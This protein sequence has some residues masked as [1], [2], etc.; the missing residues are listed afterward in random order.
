MLNI[1]LTAYSERS[2]ICQHCPM[3][4]L[5]VNEMVFLCH[6]EGFISFLVFLPC[7]YTRVLVPLFMSSSCFQTGVR[8]IF[9]LGFYIQIPWY[10]RYQCVPCTGAIYHES[11]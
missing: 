7:G 10:S 5:C 1:L 6:S 9:G 4:F 11:P 2:V 3:T 8:S